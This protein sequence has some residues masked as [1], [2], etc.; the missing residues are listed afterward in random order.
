MSVAMS[1]AASR[2]SVTSILDFGTDSEPTFGSKTKTTPSQNVIRRRSHMAQAYLSV[3]VAA[4]P[5]SRVIVC[6][7]VPVSQGEVAVT[8]AGCGSPSETQTLPFD[9]DWRLTNR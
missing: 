8:G 1:L 7:A 4:Y 6:R 2:A 5:Y 3:S 9:C